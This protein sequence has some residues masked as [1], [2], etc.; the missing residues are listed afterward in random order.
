MYNI[1]Q[2]NTTCAQS[3]TGLP[4]GGRRPYITSE[5]LLR[6]PKLDIKDVPQTSENS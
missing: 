4:L 5:N 3:R 6:T 1:S 2:V